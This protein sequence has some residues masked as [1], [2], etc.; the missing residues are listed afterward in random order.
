MPER[1][2]GAAPGSLREAIAE[3]WRALLGTDQVREEDNFFDNGG[4]SVLAVEIALRLR[5]LTD[6]ELEL[7]I[8][9]D[10]PQF[11]PLAAAVEARASGSRHQS[12][13]PLSVAEHGIW[14]FERLHPGTPAYH[15][16]ILY[17]FDGQLD[18]ARIGSALAALAV[19]HPSLRRGFTAPGEA[20]ELPFAQPAVRAVN[21]AGSDEL[22]V[23]HLLDSDARRPFELDRPPLCRALVVQRGD[24]GDLLLLTVHHLV[25][26]G[27]S[28]MMLE[29]EL[30]LLYSAAGGEDAEVP[31]TGPVRRSAPVSN[32][33]EALEFW[34]QELAGLPA[35][36]SLPYDRVRP[37]MLGVNGAVHRSELPPELLSA[38]EQMAGAERLSTFMI[39]VAA[40]VTGLVSV[41]GDRD[42]V[43]VV[44]V[45][46][47]GPGQ[48]S[49]LGMF[50]DTVPLRLVLPRRATTRA[51]VRYVR[52]VVAQCLAR[53][54]PMR[55]IIRQVGTNADSALA[56]RQTA[57][58]FVDES[59]W[60][61]RASG[62]HASRESYPTGTA[63]YELLWSV[64]GHPHGAVAELEFSTD[65]FSPEAGTRLHEQMLAAI[66]RAFANPDAELPAATAEPAG[67]G[68]T[69]ASVAE[70]VHWQAC[71]CPEAVAVTDHG[72]ALS[73]RELDQAAAAVAGELTACGL[74]RGDI[75]AVAMSRGAAAVAAFL[76]I[77]RAGCVYLPLDTAEASRRAGLIIEQSGARAVVV[78]ASTGAGPAPPSVQ[79]VKLASPFDAP[80]SGGH[81]VPPSRLT[82]QDPAYMI[83][84]S[85]STGTPKG[86]IVPHGAISR[87]VPE[88]NFLSIDAQDRVAHLSNP[89]FDAATFEIWG[90]LTSGATLVIAE[91]ETTL[92]PG[93][94]AAFLRQH[95]ISVIFLTTA[96]FN[97][98]IDFAPGAFRQLRA[99]L[100]GG[101]MHDVRRLERLLAAGP[102]GRLVHVYGPTENTTFSTFHDV[103]PADVSSGVVPIGIV[104]SG[105]TAHVIGDDGAPVAAGAVGELYL[106]GR[107]LAHGYQ[108]APAATAAA[109][110]PDPFGPAG[111]R[112]YRTGDQVRLL[113][114]GR[115]CFVGR[116]DDQVKV[117]GFRVELAEI[118]HA[119]RC[120]E[121]V[122]D[123]AAVSR[124]TDDGAQIVAYVSAPAP[125]TAGDL[126]SWLRDR[127]PDYMIPAIVILPQL[128]VNA[129]GKIDRSALAGLAAGGD[130]VPAVLPAGEAVPAGLP[131]AEGDA[132]LAGVLTLWRQVLEHKQ[133]TPE[134]DFLA[135]N[136]HS[137]K[138]MRLIARM[139]E[140]F[141]IEIDLADFFRNPT[142]SGNAALIRCALSTRVRSHHG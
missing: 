33:P 107:G 105:T 28:V 13:R 141:G 111:G 119:V 103:T 136:G 118:E 34:H 73:Y 106:G 56:F 117:R 65:L 37:R 51:L 49:E 114:D 60:Q 46:V 108:R 31:V 138:A 122:A 3:L 70:R 63:K 40:Y 97:Q 116:T 69:N 124:E 76:G 41:T 109:F 14:D 87:L 62:L 75:V 61:W 20:F 10:Y 36:R 59:G 57:L 126:A 9:Y 120:H 71:R 90:A 26:D 82:E 72:R 96:L 112:L 121:A 131:Y 55:E 48:G 133:I 6:A 19:R 50:V 64:T 42:F 15:I 39:W 52:R 32:H 17:R 21:A 129:N 89:A 83:F 54:M 79:T 100:F 84:T 5:E 74:G 66:A 58:S 127:L 125:I 22:T 140:E 78:D 132:I 99:V 92:S 98:M 142:P 30:Q 77:V 11:G 7:D 16:S 4:H 88:A 128:P 67:S 12:E 38:L 93:R 25:C 23:R 95:Q 110:V 115:L 85:G 102:P 27:E 86:V 24:A 80:V 137:I 18:V 81:A 94:L 29:A 1:E 130:T 123:V 45:S 91:R 68:S 113:P 101:E 43:I 135:L 139:D 47:R 35:L 134:S 2:A 104:V 44:P 8:L 53:Q